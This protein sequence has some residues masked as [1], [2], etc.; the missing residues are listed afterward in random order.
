MACP[1][2]HLQYFREN[3]LPDP[4]MIRRKILG[5]NVLRLRKLRPDQRAMRQVLDV[6]PDLLGPLRELRYE[7]THSRLIAFFLDANLCPAL[8]QRCLDAFL[9]RINVDDERRA[10]VTTEHFIDGGRV[11][12]RV[13]LPATLV[14]VELKVDSH[15]GDG[16]LAKY[17]A[18]LGKEKGAK[19]GVLAYMTLPDA[20]EPA[21]DRPDRHVTL[22]DLLATWL[23][24]A[25]CTGDCQGYLARYLKSL[26][27]VTGRAETGCFDEWSF[28]AQRAALDLLEEIADGQG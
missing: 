7:P 4:D 25:A 10:A 20:P 21:S 14:F 5:A 18:A 6:T 3:I 16:Q 1:S 15:E 28:A 11:D 12:I 23:P 13:E 2:S 27:L 19:T 26:A 24:V 9:R 22:D 8:G 17:R